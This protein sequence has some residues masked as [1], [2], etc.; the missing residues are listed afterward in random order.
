SLNDLAAA[1]N[2]STSAGV[3]ATVVNVAAPT[4]TPDYRLSLQSTKYNIQDI[5]LT[6]NGGT[7]DLLDIATTGSPVTYRLN[8][9]PSV[10]LIPLESDSRT[11]QVGPGTA[12]DLLSVGTSDVTISRSGTGIAT[13]I[14]SFVSAYNAVVAE[15]DNNR[16]SGTRALKGNS[17]VGS[18]SDALRRMLTYSE[19]DTDSFSNATDISFEF[20][21]TGLLSFSASDINA[22][23]ATDLE[24]LI[25]FLGTTTTGGLLKFGSDVLKSL[26]DSAGG[27]IPSASESLAGEIDNQRKRIATQDV[28]CNTWKR[29]LCSA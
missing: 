10:P 28:L 17:L 27:L 20:S 7:V 3:Q 19:N 11:L 13:A 14:N 22:L 16:G 6:T 25:N 12:L 4:A 18:V 29:I 5:T 26:D 1:I 9:Y 2:A 21:D 15:V 23:P 24:D 8:G